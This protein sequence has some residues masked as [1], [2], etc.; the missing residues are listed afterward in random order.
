[1][2]RLIYISLIYIVD[3]QRDVTLQDCK[4]PSGIFY[5]PIQKHKEDVNKIQNEHIYIF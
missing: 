5:Q 1:V 2:L 3:A 4:C